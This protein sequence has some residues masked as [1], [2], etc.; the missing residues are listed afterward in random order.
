MCLEP[1]QKLGPETRLGPS[2]LI[3]SEKKCDTQ[4]ES[5][6]MHIKIFKKV[7]LVL[8]CKA[9]E[10]KSG[11]TIFNKVM[12]L[13]KQLQAILFYFICILRLLAV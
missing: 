8:P 4:R 9:S 5:T 10:T 1:T 12:N 11:C 6:S 7:S 2:T 3:L 13:S